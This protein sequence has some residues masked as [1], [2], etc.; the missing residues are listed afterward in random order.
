M[1]KEITFKLFVSIWFLHGH[2]YSLWNYCKRRRREFG[3]GDKNYPSDLSSHRS[4]D[5]A[6]S[7]RANTIVWA[8]RIQRPSAL[9]SSY[10]REFVLMLEIRKRCIFLYESEISVINLEII[11]L[12]C[13]EQHIQRVDA[14]MSAGGKNRKCISCLSVAW[15]IFIVC[16]RAFVTRL[17]YSSH[18]IMN[19]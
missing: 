8:I 3:L 18:M 4:N 1:I 19:L 6:M 7:F 17:K 10:P 16:T 2:E 15:C 12:E 9:S 13:S 11:F 14:K 5:I